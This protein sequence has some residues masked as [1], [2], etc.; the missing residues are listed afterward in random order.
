[1]EE[2]YIY[3]LKNI[4]KYSKGS[5]FGDCA[6]IEFTPPDMSI[7]DETGMLEQLVMGAIVSAT[8]GAERSGTAPVKEEDKI[9]GPEEIRMLLMSAQDIK[10]KDISDIFKVIAIKTG[11]VDEKIF[12]TNTLINKLDINDYKEMLFGYIGFFIFPSLL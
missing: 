11:K 2:N 7:L 6:S 1:M 5:D 10:I 8:K 9:P 4:L 3:Q 12:L